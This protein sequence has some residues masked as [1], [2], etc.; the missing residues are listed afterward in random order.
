M[1]RAFRLAAGCAIAAGVV[2]GGV[3]ATTSIGITA[4]TGRGT[5]V[6]NINANKKFGPGERVRIKTSGNIDVVTQRIVAAP[7]GTFGW[8]SHPGENVNVIKSGTL[9]LYH[10]D[11]CAT[12]IHYGPGSSFY[13]QTGK[14]HLARTL[15]AT[16]PVVFFAT[17]FLPS[18][19]PSSLIRTDEPSPGPGCPE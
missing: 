12:P 16:E 2:A 3:L 6:E 4:E 13:M 9:T 5:L 11:A 14:V 18:R 7:G 15:N 19:T 1:R 17:Y 10:A 8:H